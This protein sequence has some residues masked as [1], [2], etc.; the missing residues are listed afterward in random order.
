[1]ANR[2]ADDLEKFLASLSKV[3]E[4]EGA[5]IVSFRN[6]KKKRA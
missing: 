3:E 2:V 1:M 6:A 4:E 5:E